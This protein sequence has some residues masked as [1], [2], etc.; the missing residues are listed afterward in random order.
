MFV[1]QR[2]RL[3]K[4]RTLIEIGD[5]LGRGVPVMTRRGIGCDPYL[6]PFLTW[7]LQMI[8]D[9]GLEFVFT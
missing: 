2:K 8:P 5:K 4:C 6:D 7:E 1:F 3:P 9:Q